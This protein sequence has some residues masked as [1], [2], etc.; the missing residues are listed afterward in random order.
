MAIGASE[1]SRTFFFANLT[2]V[3]GLNGK[4]PHPNCVDTA[5]HVN[6]T[7]VSGPPESTIGGQLAIKAGPGKWED[8]LIQ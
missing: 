8:G 6:S 7:S 2:H 5:S 1:I 3:K 4:N